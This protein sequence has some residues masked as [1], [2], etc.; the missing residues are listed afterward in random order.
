MRWDSDSGTKL[1]ILKQT[2]QTSIVAE[3]RTITEFDTLDNNK[4]F[5]GVIVY[6]IDVGKD[7][8]QNAIKLIT[9][10]FFI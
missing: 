8:N 2:P 7:S 10:N 1:V 4:D 5:E 3:Y 9:N 6:K